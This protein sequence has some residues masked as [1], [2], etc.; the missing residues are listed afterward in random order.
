M[1][2]RGQIIFKFNSG[3]ICGKNYTQKNVYFKESYWWLN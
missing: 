2:F 3:R 1:N